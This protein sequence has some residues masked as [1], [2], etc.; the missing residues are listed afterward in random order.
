MELLMFE[1]ISKLLVIANINLYV[2]NEAK[3]ASFFI[4]EKDM[5]TLQTN[6]E[7][8]YGF[9]KTCVITIKLIDGTQFDVI[10]ASFEKC[11]SYSN[12]SQKPRLL[13]YNNPFDKTSLVKEVVFKLK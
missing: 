8:Y 12:Y 4:S 11:I 5:E 9:I 10:P 3:F 2:P 6:L 1:F 13:F 7:G